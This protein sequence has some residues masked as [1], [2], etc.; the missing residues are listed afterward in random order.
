[1]YNIF[2]WFLWWKCLRLFR[3]ER[4]VLLFRVGRCTTSYLL[5]RPACLWCLCLRSKTLW[6]LFLNITSKVLQVI[7]FHT[8]VR[9]STSISS[10]IDPP[11]TKKK[12]K[13]RKGKKKKK[14]KKKKKLTLFL[15]QLKELFILHSRIYLW[16]WEH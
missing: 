1:M 2:N 6:G 10:Q 8:L 4:I 13:K 16:S 15:H 3:L 11:P 5:A 14:K 7:N 12:G 9:K